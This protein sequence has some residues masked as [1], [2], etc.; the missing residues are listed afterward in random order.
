MP[1]DFYGINHFGDDGV[2]RSLAANRTVLGFVELNNQQLMQAAL[3]KDE[4]TYLHLR[5]VW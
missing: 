4:T 3:D 1:L 5:S 2:M